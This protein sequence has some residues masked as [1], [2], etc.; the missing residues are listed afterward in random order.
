MVV[1]IQTVVLRL[2]WSGYKW[3]G[4]TSCVHLRYKRH[5]CL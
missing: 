4:E 2:I 1:K 3:S 5:F